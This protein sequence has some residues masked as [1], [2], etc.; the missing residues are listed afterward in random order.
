MDRIVLQGLEFHGYHG[1]FPEEAKFGARFVVDVELRTVLGEDDTLASTVDY[2]AVYRL[3]AEEVTERRYRLIETLAQAIARRVL[4]DVP[5]VEQ[6]TVRVHKPHA[7]LPGVVRDV[8][9]EVARP[10][11]GYRR[12][13]EARHDHVRQGDARQVDAQSNDVR[14]EAAQSDDDRS[15]AAPR[16]IE[17]S[18]RT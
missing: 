10:Q 1:V 2:S 9:V 7:P 18:D 13:D 11:P 14:S 16:P 15:E 8:F 3:V 6:V 17:R 12:Q 5:R 4:S